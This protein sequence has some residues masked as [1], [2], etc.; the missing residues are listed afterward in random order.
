MIRTLKEFGVDMDEAVVGG[1][2]PVNILAS[3]EKDRSRE[4]EDFYG[5][6]VA[7]FSRESME[8]TNKRGEAAIHLAAKNGH[9]GMLKAMMEKGANINL[10]EDSPAEAGIT[11]LHLACRYGHADAVRLL[12]AAGADDSAKNAKGETA[13]HL[14]LMNP[15]YGKKTEP[16]QRAEILRE[17]KNLD[18]E[19]DDGR[20][21]LMLL[22]YETRELLRLFLDRGADV[23]HRDN[24][25][26]T[27]L[28]LYSDKEMIKELLLAGA[29]LTLADREGNTALHHALKGYNTGTARYL[30]RK[31]ADYN[32]PNNCGETPAQIA[33][34]KGEEDVLELM[35]D[36]H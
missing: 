22:Q 18:V 27:A 14:A 33:V 10:T 24:N 30:I 4:G 2:T 11:P 9:T 16:K 35:T 6:A 36:I 12:V 34:E 1:Q 28:M 17:L 13:A 5:E 19:R 32:R 7:F 20:T 8:Q 26:M 31:G 15:G 25:G 29:D 21:P 3:C 23:N